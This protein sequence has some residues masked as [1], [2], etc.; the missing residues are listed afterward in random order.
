MDVTVYSGVGEPVSK[1]NRLVFPDPI[2]PVRMNL[3]C[4]GEK[5]DFLYMSQ[6]LTSTSNNVKMIG[7]IITGDGGFLTE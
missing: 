3:L 7:T 6:V 5:S 2:G 4:F 1:W